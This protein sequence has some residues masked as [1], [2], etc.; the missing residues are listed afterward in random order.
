MRSSGQSPYRRKGKS[1][2][3]KL[4]G[5]ITEGKVKVTIVTMG[6]RKPVRGLLLMHDKGR[7]QVY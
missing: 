4:F 1:F 7:Y 3:G 6:K 5:R 2:T